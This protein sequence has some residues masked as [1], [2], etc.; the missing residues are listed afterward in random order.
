VPETETRQGAW[1]ITYTHEASD[2]NVQASGVEI[3]RRD[4]T[5]VVTGIIVPGVRRL[6][7]LAGCKT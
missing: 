6:T 1:A 2:S 5:E 7:L 4:V 3:V